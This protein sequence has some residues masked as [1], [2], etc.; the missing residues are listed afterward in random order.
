MPYQI[1]VTP[2]NMQ[3]LTDLG[4]DC[5]PIS[6]YAPFSNTRRRG[7][8]LIV[9]TGLPR[10]TWK[11][12]ELTFEELSTLLYYVSTGGVLQASKVVYIRT[13]VDN[14][15]MTDR[16]FQDYKAIMLLPFEP[17]DVEYVTNRRFADVN[18]RFINAEAI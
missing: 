7:D 16:V 1:G 4:I 13:R 5:Q 10:I 12:Q 17:E 9:G 3:E 2:A 15:T 14:D 6:E 8:G 11:F 18:V